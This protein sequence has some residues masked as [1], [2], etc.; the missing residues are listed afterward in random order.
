MSQRKKK[1]K[2]SNNK[3]YLI[4]LLILVL[5]VLVSSFI[6]RIINVFSGLQTTTDD[7][8][9]TGILLVI[10]FVAIYLMDGLDTIRRRSK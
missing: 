7:V 1:G 2:N 4:A 8:F 3:L 9:I 10:V 5:F 6:N